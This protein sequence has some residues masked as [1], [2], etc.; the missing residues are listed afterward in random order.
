ME[1]VT[2]EY[3]DTGCEGSPTGV[4]GGG[5]GVLR[6]SSHCWILDLGEV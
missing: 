3:M 2:P 5:A 6:A 1:L 4:G